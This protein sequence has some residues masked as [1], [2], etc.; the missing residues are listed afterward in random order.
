M[1]DGIINGSQL[2]DPYTQFTEVN[3]LNYK[4]ATNPTIEFLVEKNIR[5]EIQEGNYVIT[6]TKPT[7]VNV[8]GTILKPNSSNSKERLIYDCSR[9]HWHAVFQILVTG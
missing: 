2:A 1:V 6:A 5:D 9:P 7:V 8:L 4:W 3:I